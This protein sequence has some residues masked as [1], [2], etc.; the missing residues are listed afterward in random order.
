MALNGALG[1]LVAVT[2]PL[3]PSPAIAVF[4]GAI[5]GVLV[6]LSVPLL[7][8]LKVDDVV[9]AIPVHLVAGIWGTIA[10]VFSN[11]DASLV[12]QIIG[13]VAI[14]AFV[15]VTTGIVWTILK[16]TIGIRASEE[17]EF[18]G[19]DQAECGLEAYPE[20]GQGAQSM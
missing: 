1:G 8:K 3:A 2:E 10:V 19:L 6:V 18:S 12:T 17:E 7:D 20:F 14:G 13:I 16:M 9:G 4:V 15:L 5:G 11:G